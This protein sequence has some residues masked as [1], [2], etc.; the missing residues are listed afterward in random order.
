MR[1]IPA[2]VWKHIKPLRICALIQMVKIIE[3]QT[4]KK[5]Y[6]LKECNNQGLGTYRRTA[7][8]G[9]NLLILEPPLKKK[10][11]RNIAFPVFR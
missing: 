7:G 1:G 10:R 3:T 5:K 4:Y 2:Q 11:R 9:F 8:A 6:A